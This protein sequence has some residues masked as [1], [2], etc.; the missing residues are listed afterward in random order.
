[1]Y[2]TAL[3]DPPTSRATGPIYAGPGRDLAVVV[4]KNGTSASLFE[5]LVA[6]W[7]RP[8]GGFICVL[9]VHPHRTCAV[10]RWYWSGSSR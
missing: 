8:Y 1:M 9:H 3:Y 6:A 10:Q 4:I 2:G 7:I 5:C